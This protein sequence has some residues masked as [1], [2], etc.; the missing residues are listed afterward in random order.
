MEEAPTKVTRLPNGLTVIT[1]Y[2]PTEQAH[3]ALDVSVGARYENAKQAGISHFIEH[4]LLKKTKDWDIKQQAEKV[5]DAYGYMNA[6][7]SLENTQYYYHVNKAYVPQ[8]IKMLA[9]SM[10]RAEMTPESV[11]NEANTIF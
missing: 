9:D 4:M 8:M 3:V 2:Q 10:L 11:K 6:F 5:R 7:T 1:S